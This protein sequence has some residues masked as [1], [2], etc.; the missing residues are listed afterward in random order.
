MKLVASVRQH[1]GF[2]LPTVLIASVVLL[3][4]LAVSVTATTSARTALKNQYYTQL[5]QIAGEAG[6]AFALACLEANAN[7]PQW[8]APLTPATNCAGVV[9][10]GYPTSVTLNGNVRSSFSVPV[11]TGSN[12]DSDGRA[13]TIPQS[14]FVE[15][16]RE[17]NGDVFRTYRQ[18]AAQ[19]A[20]VPGLCA[21]AAQTNLGW[22]NAQITTNAAA[23]FPETSAQSISLGSGTAYAPGPV[24]F[25][26]DFNAPRAGTYTVQV[27]ADDQ[28]HL[29]I[30]GRLITKTNFSSDINTVD[31]QLDA[32]CHVVHVKVLND[33][34]LT[35]GNNMYLDFAL[36]EKNE[37]RPLIVSDRSW[38]VSA[39]TT[40]VFGQA[41]MYRSVQ[42]ANARSVGAYNA[43]PWA[44]PAGWVTA[45][46]DTSAQWIST[47]HSFTGNNYPFASY[48]YF[49]TDDYGDWSFA[50]PTEVQLAIA[51]DDNC[52]LV[53]DGEPVLTNAN[54]SVTSTAKITL[55]AGQHSIGVLLYNGNTATNPSAFLFSARR[56]SDSV[57]I[58]RSSNS[59]LAANA[60]YSTAQ[61][62][63]SYDVGYRPSPDIYDCNCDNQGSS[64]ITSNP[65]LEVNETNMSYLRATNSRTSAAA[66]SGSFG[67]RAT[68]N[69]VGFFP[70]AINNVYD[71]D[72]GQVYTISGHIRASVG[73]RIGYQF[74]DSTG[75]SIL[76]NG[77]GAFLGTA[78]NPAGAWQRFSMTTLPV[79]PGTARLQVW[80]GVAD[81]TPISTVFDVDAVM[82]SPGTALHPYLDGSSS[83][84]SWVGPVH[85]SE[86]SG[87]L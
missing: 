12:L 63:L 66:F 44:E 47:N 69:A 22:S 51:C 59:M 61:S 67:V 53:V 23:P 3:T 16:L 9:Q 19:A 17:S 39:G 37:N 31:L 79:P 15:L 8:T 52:V 35:L 50:T 27:R 25:R 30:D 38:R 5:A 10:A 11:L 71:V 6:A 48:S 54:Y 85:G 40:A 57:I 55:S 84:W 74:V 86:S 4:I 65:S 2:A 80:L 24:H 36:R 43:A 87:P 70:R 75:A 42:Y 45:T 20:V 1:K 21:G 62:I 82:V 56:T 26:K 29:Y 76:V 46:A 32:G 49:V 72:I 13:V 7:I 34:I 41:S 83:G 73:S 77:N 68:V 18:P 64:N 58:D 78:S 33:N 28:A 60:W 81:N 14:G